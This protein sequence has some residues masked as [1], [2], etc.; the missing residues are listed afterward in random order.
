MLEIVTDFG[1]AVFILPASL[2]VFVCLWVARAR[3]VALAWA[4]AL[5]LCILLLALSKLS[6][7]ACGEWVASLDIRSPSG[8][9]GL[10]TAF[11]L[12]GAAIFAAGR[13]PQLRRWLFMSSVLL[14]GAIAASRVILGFHSPAEIAVG[15]VIGA[16]SMLVFRALTVGKIEILHIPR[17]VPALLILLAVGAHGQHIDAERLIAQW[18]NQLRADTKI[19]VATASTGRLSFADADP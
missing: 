6:F 16:I 17:A 12:S 18:S 13:A 1:D 4:A 2:V 9:V 3:R 5:L 8:H 14:I 15:L 7:R 19:C 10:A 11:Y